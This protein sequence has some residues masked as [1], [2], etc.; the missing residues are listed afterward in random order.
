MDEKDKNLLT[1]YSRLN[2]ELVDAR[3]ELARLNATLADRERFLSRVLSISPSVVYI[4]DLKSAEYAYSSRPQTS[5]LGFDD[6][7][8][9]EISGEKEAL[10]GNRK[11]LGSA[12]EGEVRTAVFSAFHADGSLR[13]LQA[14]ETVFSRSGD[15][16][17]LY[18]LGV[19]DD[20]TLQKEREDAL[21]K[22]SVVDSLTGLHNRRGFV[23]SARTLLHSS[24]LR[25]TPC[26]LL[27]FDLDDFKSINDTHGHE[28]GDA[29][30]VRFAEGL[31]R[32]FRT[33]DIISRFGGDEFVV[34]AVDMTE[35]HLGALLDRMRKVMDS[36]DR[37]ERRPWKLGWSLGTAFSAPDEKPDLEM[38]IRK[39]DGL[40]YR[41]KTD[42]KKVLES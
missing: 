28:Q 39:A 22:D 40:M 2:N 13:W 5:L 16:G 19:L 8:A 18:V 38:M 34:F 9:L 4:Y 37:V 32:T 15:G 1:E 41:D 11:A 23:A 14:K 31:R 7:R 12:G 10:E 36:L 17:V 24:F 35:R 33:S 20:V 3:R 27:F 6:G 26:A 42:R 21:R 25:G 29:A 30:L